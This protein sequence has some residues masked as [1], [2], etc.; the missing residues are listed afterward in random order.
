VSAL[1]DIILADCPWPYYGDPNKDAAAGKHYALLSLGEIA[2]IPV[3]SMASPSAA[4]FMWATCPR[5]PDALE[6]MKAWG[7][8]FRSVAF[9]W[10]KTRR[11]GAIIHGQGVQPTFT[12]PTTELL[13]AGTR[14]KT[15]RAFPLLDHAMGQVVLAPRGAHRT[16]RP[17]AYRGVGRPRTR[18]RRHPLGDAVSGSILCRIGIHLFRPW[19]VTSSAGAY[20]RQYARR[21]RFCDREEAFSYHYPRRMTHD[22]D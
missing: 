1:Y 21:C 22:K 9:I 14:K 5:L 19:R 6:T 10:V 2:A 18:P 15:G 7:W 20:P 16:L 17:R 12:K 13:L 4:L 8:Y 3:A 11:D